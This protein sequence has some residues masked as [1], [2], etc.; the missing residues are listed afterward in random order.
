MEDRN[1][2]AKRIFQHLAAFVVTGSLLF[3]SVMASAPATAA[4]KAT[5]TPT[6]PAGPTPT[7]P[8]GVAGGFKTSGPK[9]LNPSNG[10]FII[11]GV[12]WFG[13]ET[14][15][16]V[17]HGLWAVD[18]QTMIN[19]IKAYGFNTIR[20]PYSDE[21]WRTNPVPNN[22]SGCPACV[23]KHSRDVMALI[24]N[25]AGSIGLH[26]IIDNHRSEAGNS[27]ESSGL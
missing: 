6:S 21:M 26:V 16:T 11:A 24:V 4:G 19:N 8:G 9:I 18:Y 7:P 13:F 10:E 12:N 17:A 3:A 25:Y 27:A 20:I 15:D 23:G 14:R 22:D 5:A 1:M 2:Q